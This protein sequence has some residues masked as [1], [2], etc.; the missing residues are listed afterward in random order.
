MWLV[1]VTYNL[2][3]LEINEKTMNN[4]P[5]PY[6]MP[7]N[8]DTVKKCM[9]FSVRNNVYDHTL[10][11]HNDGSLTLVKH[12]WEYISKALTARYAESNY[13][14]VAERFGIKEKEDVVEAQQKLAPE[15][16]ATFVR[17]KNVMTTTA[18]QQG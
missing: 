13:E 15:E 4:L 16:P 6:N 8:M 1:L 17:R 10:L 11:C 12:K 3:N 7:I 5:T 18:I 14:S 2:M 9:A